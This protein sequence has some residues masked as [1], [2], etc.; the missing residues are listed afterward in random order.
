MSALKKMQ[1]MARAENKRMI[2]DEI[3]RTRAT[4]NRAFQTPDAKFESR[5]VPR[6][7]SHLRAG[8][9][10]EDMQ[11]AGTCTADE[12]RQ[13]IDWMRTNGSLAKFYGHTAQERTT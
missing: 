5:M 10:V 7:M 6:V 13:V 1:E 11:V 3:H 12:A 8:D 4:P 9:G 2:R